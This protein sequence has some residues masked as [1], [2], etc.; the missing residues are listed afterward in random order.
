[1]IEH[2]RKSHKHRDGL[3]VSGMFMRQY[4]KGYWKPQG[5]ARV[6]WSFFVFKKLFMKKLL[7]VLPVVLI[8]LGSGC[9]SGTPKDLLEDQINIIESNLNGP[10]SYPIVGFGGGNVGLAENIETCRQTF[11]SPNCYYEMSQHQ[12]TGNF[13]PHHLSPEEY[14]N[15]DNTIKLSSRGY[16]SRDIGCNN[17]IVACSDLLSFSKLE[18]GFV[19]YP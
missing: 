3:T 12:I 8:L 15:F 18:Q 2:G 7:C 14:K 4:S 13:W 16:S 17:I 1:M 5:F 11:D 9:S 10:P 19:L 6:R